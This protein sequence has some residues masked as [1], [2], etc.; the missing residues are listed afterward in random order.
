LR[1]EN[2]LPKDIV[3]KLE[4]CSYTCPQHLV[5]EASSLPKDIVKKLEGSSHT[6]PQHLVLEARVKI[7]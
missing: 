2:V 5:L 3:K 1:R 7:S 6:R 4:G